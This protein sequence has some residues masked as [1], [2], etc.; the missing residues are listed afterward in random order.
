MCVLLYPFL[1]TDHSGL[2][3]AF[4]ERLLR[5]DLSNIAI[6]KRPFTLSAITP[7]VSC[8]P[9]LCRDIHLPRAAFSTDG[10]HQSAESVD[11][12][13]SSESGTREINLNVTNTS[14][15]AS[16]LTVSHDCIEPSAKRIS[17]EGAA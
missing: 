15:R 14:N 13:Q 10:N 9:S 12:N 5:G 6:V 1:T 3:V 7:P 2:L 16:F 4:T 8:P 17:V 11:S